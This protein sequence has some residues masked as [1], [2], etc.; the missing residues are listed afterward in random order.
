MIERLTKLFFITIL[1][2]LNGCE[3]KSHYSSKH[4]AKIP[5]VI[6]APNLMGPIPTVE[7]ARQL[8]IKFPN[9]GYAY[10]LLGCAYYKRKEYIKAISAFEKSLDLDPTIIGA[11]YGLAYS[12][13][14]LEKW[15]HIRL[16]WKKLLQLPL[17]TK[18]DI[19]A[20]YIG[21]GNVA[22]DQHRQTKDVN[23]LSEAE[24]AY[25][26]ALKVFPQKVDAYYGLGIVFARKQQ[27][28]RAK[29]LFEMAFS[30]SSTPRDKA[31]SLEALANIWLEK[32]DQEHAKRLIEQA[33]KIDPNYPA[34][35]F[36]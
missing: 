27:W 3:K 32:G 30:L 24:K 25:Q 21:L 33:R 28:D 2:L 16:I 13:N 9:S 29:E 36:Q 4:G 18:E 1:V 7:K 22:L 17:P 31:K 19:Y 26:R 10:Y 23:F 5:R 8:V 11:Y 20:A 34:T 35:L 12:Y 14:I 15:D 6:R